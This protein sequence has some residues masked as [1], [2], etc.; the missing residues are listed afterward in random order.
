M[1]S[2]V[3]GHHMRMCERQ[4]PSVPWTGGR[5][6]VTNSQRRRCTARSSDCAATRVD[7]RRQ[8]FGAPR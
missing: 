5:R 3:V 4:R 8:H 2:G 6:G 7:E 1:A